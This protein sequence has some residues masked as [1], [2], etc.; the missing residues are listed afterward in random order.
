M[1]KDNGDYK[2][3]LRQNKLEDEQEYSFMKKEDSTTEE[4][5]SEEK[6]REQFDAIG[7][8]EEALA[9]F[10]EKATENKAM[11]NSRYM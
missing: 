8:F 11:L 7:A 5:D 10:R 6:Q 3:F 1:A 4:N 9:T 2:E